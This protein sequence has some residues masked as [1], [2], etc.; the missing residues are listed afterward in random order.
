MAVSVRLPPEAGPYIE[1]YL[2]QSH[3][4]LLNLESSRFKF[5]SI[6]SLIAHYAQC[7]DE[8]PVQLGLPKALSDAINRQQLL[9]LALLGSEFWRNAISSVQQPKFT[10][11]EDSHEMKSPTE[12]SGIS[13]MDSSLK[14]T[15]TL[16]RINFLCYY[17]QLFYFLNR[18]V[19]CSILSLNF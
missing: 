8:L 2:V 5:D 12:T 9:S 1:H 17:L 19:L 3:D 6:P 4:G 13:T 7:C 14:K 15:S 16:V 18:R 10:P 11:D